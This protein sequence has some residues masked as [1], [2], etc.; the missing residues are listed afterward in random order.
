MSLFPLAT[1]RQ[2]RP[3]SKPN[4]AVWGYQPNELNQ[5]TGVGGLP[6]SYDAN[7]NLTGFDGLSATYDA[8]N[9]LVSASKN[10]TTV[11]F[12]Y[13]GLGRCVKRT[14]NGA[15]TVIVYDGWKPIVDWD[16]AGSK[17]WNIYGPG[18]DEILWRM[19]ANFG[20]LRYKL[21][22]QGNV[23]FLLDWAGNILEK[24]SY[25]AFGKPTVTSRDLNSWA[26]KPPT[27]RSEFGNRFMFTGR[28][29]IGEL[30]IYDYRRRFYQPFLGR[31]LQVDPT[32]LHIEGEKLSA[33]QKALFSPGGQAPE[34]FSSSEMNLYRYCG[35]DPVDKTDPLGLLTIIIGGY[36]PGQKD[37]SDL[38][39]SNRQFYE[40]AKATDPSNS[41]LFGR[42][43]KSEMIKKIQEAREKGDKT[44]N[45]FGYS[46]GAVAGVQLA[47]ELNKRGISVD[48][49]VT[50]DPVRV[51]AF[52]DGSRSFNVPGNVKQAEN[53]YQRG[54][55][56]G[57][58]DFPGTR[59][60]GNV[61][62][63]PLGGAAPYSGRQ[64]THQRMPSIVA[65]IG[66]YED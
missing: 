26:W 28:E 31:F 37:D 14:I 58:W 9:R 24:Y 11:Q 57:F 60:T 65:E 52:G 63:Y 25:D 50:I 29:W 7:F 17:S 30:G 46:R 51:R 45:I 44:L 55:R 16:S 35:D 64:I 12:L 53:Y 6:L 38:R 41:Q 10:G 15:A 3:S 33:G 22:G 66:G 59:L 34:A 2:G 42:D 23:A 56:S 39:Y 19:Q 49:L 8:A 48:R 40:Y 47:Q 18:P 13:D 5:Y 1:G 32:G 21:D 20:H 43:Q 54:S 36:G 27:D 4:G 62:N 61:Q